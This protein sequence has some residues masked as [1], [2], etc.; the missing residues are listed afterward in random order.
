MVGL[1]VGSFVALVWW[2]ASPV[3]S[4]SGLVSG[5][6]PLALSSSP[7]SGGRSSPVS[8]GGTLTLRTLVEKRKKKL[9]N[10][11]YPKNDN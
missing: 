1:V 4:C 5:G 9:I 3:A 10:E 7:V 2:L 11:K 8:G 6:A